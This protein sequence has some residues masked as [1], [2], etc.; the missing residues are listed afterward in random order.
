MIVDIWLSRVM[1]GLVSID[2]V[3]AR[4]RDSVKELIK[5]LER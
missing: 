1:L 3:P 5:E 2:K 4:Y